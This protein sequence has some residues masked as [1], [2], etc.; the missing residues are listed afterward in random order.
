MAKRWRL[1]LNH[2]TSYAVSPT[3]TPIRRSHKTPLSMRH[4]CSLAVPAR[5]PLQL[6]RPDNLQYLAKA[7]EQWIVVGLIRSTEGH[8]GP[9][10]RGAPQS[11][12]NTP[13]PQLQQD[14]EPQYRYFYLEGGVVLT[15]P[16]LLLRVESKP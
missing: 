15:I 9:S 16:T 2:P 4:L 8:D 7:L 13:D 5:Q 1:E 10:V 14:P 3:A 12:A 6:H 11:A